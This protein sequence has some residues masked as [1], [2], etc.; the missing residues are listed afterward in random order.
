VVVLHRMRRR[1]GNLEG[2]PTNSEYVVSS[3]EPR[4]AM[5]QS[6]AQQN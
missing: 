5:Q 1:S 3:T 4:A 2:A 6:F